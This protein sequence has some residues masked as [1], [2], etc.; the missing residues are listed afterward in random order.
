FTKVLEA[1]PS[2]G[3]AQWGIAMSPWGNPFG[4]LRQRKV[5]Q[6]RLAAAE[7]AQTI[8]AKTDRERDY[9]AAVALLY[10]DA[11]TLDHRARTAAYEKAME[12][13]YNQYTNDH[14]A[15]AS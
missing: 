5:L 7:K 3:I 4:G 2:C 12:R 13:I 15:A 14:E 9:I 6:H 1:D 10:K 8:G 11:E